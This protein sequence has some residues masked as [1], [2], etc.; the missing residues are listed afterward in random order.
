MPGA[1]FP[2]P[3]APG[4]T[5]WTPRP[6]SPRTRGP[7]GSPG[8]GVRIDKVGYGRGTT[9]LPYLA[10]PTPAR[11]ET[12]RS[13][14]RRVPALARWLAP[15]LG[16]SALS[17]RPLA[18]PLSIAAR[19]APGPGPPPAPPPF[20]PTPDLPLPTGPP[21][22]SR[23]L[24]RSLPCASGSWVFAG[25]PSRSCPPR[26]AESSG[27][28]ALRRSR[29]LSAPSTPRS[30]RMQPTEQRARDT[31]LRRSLSPRRC[32]QCYGLPSL[33]A[34]GLALGLQGATGSWGR[35]HVGDR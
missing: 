14:G 11:R 18:R 33:R 13:R 9:G 2:L 24:H 32:T 20:L 6:G 31:G 7:C 21:P 1:V 25:L 17:A 16:S 35:G 4:S 28:P 8:H 23:L 29:C 30:E 19:P 10:C 22:P 5:V 34:E 26:G 3:G 15:S 27:T 12:E